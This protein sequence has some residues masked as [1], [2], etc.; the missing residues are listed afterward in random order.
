MY[1]STFNSYFNEDNMDNIQKEELVCIICWESNGIVEDLQIIMKKSH[2]CRYVGK[3]H[4]KCLYK[5]FNKN[6]YCPMCRETVDNLSIIN[7]NNNFD[8][9]IFLSKTINIL[10]FF[11]KYYNLLLY[12][13]CGYFIIY[14]IYNISTVSFLTN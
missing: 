11:L 12:T 14:S 13:L 2:T 10:L 6:N 4:D 7:N 3:F 5:W 9:S 8:I 1:F